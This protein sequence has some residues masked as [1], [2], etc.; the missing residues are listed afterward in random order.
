MTGYLDRLA[1]LLREAHGLP[2]DHVAAVVADLGSYL[3]RAGGAEPEDA[4]GPVDAFARRLAPDRASAPADEHLETWCFLADT[5]AGEELLN[6]FGDEGWEVE[7]IDPPGRFVSHRDPERPRR[8]EYR[9][10]VATGAGGS[11]AEQLA[12]DERLARDG[13]EPCGDWVVYAW[14]KRPKAAATDPVSAPA[15]PPPAPPR[16]RGFLHLALR[17]LRG[18]RR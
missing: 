6:R 9:R 12:R 2:A 7:R 1:E 18:R 4:F 15:G 8:W 11:R 3:A 5:Y 17:T 10:E 16:R 14:F 13:W